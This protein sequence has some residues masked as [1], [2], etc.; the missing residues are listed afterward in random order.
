MIPACSQEKTP[1]ILSSLKCGRAKDF[2]IGFIKVRL[3]KIFIKNINV[4]VTRQQF[5]FSDLYIL[6]LLI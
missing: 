6:T 1:K 2:Q 4:S 3:L 5:L